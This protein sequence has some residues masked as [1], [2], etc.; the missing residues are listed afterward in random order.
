MEVAAISLPVYYSDF[1]LS[2]SVHHRAEKGLGTSDKYQKVI[3]I[4]CT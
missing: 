3:M 1:R 4:D 2:I